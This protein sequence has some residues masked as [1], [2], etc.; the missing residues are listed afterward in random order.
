MK[1][2][3]QKIRAEIN[4]IEIKTTTAKINETKSCLFEKIHKIDEPLARLIKNKRERTQINKI[5][6]EKRRN[7]NRKGGN[8]KD[9][10][11]LPQ[12]TIY[13]YLKETDKFL[14]RY[15]HPRVKQGEIENMNTP[16]TSTEI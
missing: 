4:E 6:N 12:A 8:T 1:E 7:Y 5:K 2:I 11:K 14:E 10:K 13:Q 9:R 3:N 15:N 16:I